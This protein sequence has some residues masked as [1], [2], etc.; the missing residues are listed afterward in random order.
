VTQ[1]NGVHCQVDGPSNEAAVVTKSGPVKLEVDLSKG[2]YL[3]SIRTDSITVE[4][5]D[6]KTGEVI[7]LICSD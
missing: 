1:C 3:Q 2:T 4:M 5:Y 6:R 7:G